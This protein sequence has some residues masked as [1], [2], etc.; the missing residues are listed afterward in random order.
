MTTDPR[1]DRFS[2]LVAASARGRLDVPYCPHPDNA[3]RS[4]ATI[5]RHA[6]LSRSRA[7]SMPV[8]TADIGDPAA[9]AAEVDARSPARTLSHNERRFDREERTGSLPAGAS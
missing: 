5:D 3:N 4:R 9:A 8:S 2:A 6:M 1:T 7:G